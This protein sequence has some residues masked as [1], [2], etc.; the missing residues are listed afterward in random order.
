MNH[1]CNLFFLFNPSWKCFILFYFLKSSWNQPVDKMTF[2]V[3]SLSSP[4][5]SSPSS[6]IEFFPSSELRLAKYNLHLMISQLEQSVAAFL[7]FAPAAQ[8]SR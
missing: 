5:F 6:L 3:V 8:M 2:T 7:L 4:L 1:F